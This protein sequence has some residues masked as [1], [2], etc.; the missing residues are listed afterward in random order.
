MVGFAPPMIAGAWIR[1]GGPRYSYAPLS[2]VPFGQVAVLPASRRGLPAR[3]LVVEP[4]GLA[5]GAP[6]S[7]ADAVDFSRQ[8]N[9]LPPSNRSRGSVVMLVVAPPV[10]QSIS[11]GG[12]CELEGRSL[13]SHVAWPS[14]V[15]C[16]P[17][18]R[19]ELSIVTSAGGA[20]N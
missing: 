13:Y 7:I 10:A 2:L 1:H 6:E 11:N 16:S 3:S 19:I 14:P 20:P 18:T 8:S 9:G 17:S 12:A 4:G 15:A 5:P